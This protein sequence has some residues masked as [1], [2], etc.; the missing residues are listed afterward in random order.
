MPRHSEK[1]IAVALDLNFRYAAEIFQGVSD[2]IAKARLDWRLL[3]LSFG[4]EGSIMDLAASGQ[5]DGVIGSFISDRWIAGLRQHRIAAVNLFQLSRI[6]SIPS[7]CIDD[8]EMGRQAA[9]HL[10]EQTACSFVF[11]SADN[12]YSTQLRREGF[13]HA[14][15]TKTILSLRSGPPLSHNLAQLHALPRPVGVFCSSDRMARELIHEARRQGWRIG[16]DLLVLGS[17]NDPSESIFAEIGISSFQLP[18]HAI[19][20]RAAQ[21]L[22]QAQAEACQSD[23]LCDAIASRIIARESTLAPGRARLAQ[24]AI[25]YI[26][27]RLSD[28][29][30]DVGQLARTLGASR[31]SL[32]LAFQ[33]QFRTSPYRKLSDL[34]LNKAGEL[35]TST[36]L[37]IEAV[38][39]HC[40]Y[41]EPHHFSAWFKKQTGHA[42]KFYRAA[43]SK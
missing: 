20:Y 10:S 6:C 8:F 25:H 31:R 32:E 9:L 38:G 43:H 12:I 35:L 11:Y 29:K 37:S 17:D 19:G 30:L 41:P 16:Q 36:T 21:R 5:L 26:E 13:Q 14:L 27:E 23:P 2:Y 34:R 42:P 3:P 7:V 18:T 33:K 4:F 28:S 15:S 24:T 40:G 1:L 39:Q 22:R